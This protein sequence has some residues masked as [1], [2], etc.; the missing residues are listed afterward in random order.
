MKSV[1]FL[2]LA[3]IPADI[4]LIG[5][6][7]AFL[8][9]CLLALVL[10]EKRTAPKPPPLPGSGIP[11]ST[12]LII[13][14]ILA[15]PCILIG[16]KEYKEAVPR[17]EEEKRLAWLNVRRAVENALVACH[18][19]RDMHESDGFSLDFVAAD[20]AISRFVN[21]YPNEPLAKEYLR[22]AAPKIHE[23]VASPTQ[24]GIDEVA[25]ILNNAAGRFGFMRPSESPGAVAVALPEVIE[26][27]A[28]IRESL[29]PSQP[30]PPPAPE[31]MPAVTIPDAPKK[32]RFF[33]EFADSSKPRCS[34]AELPRTQIP[35]FLKAANFP[36]GVPLRSGAAKLDASQITQISPLGIK[37][38]T[39][40]GIDLI[41]WEA[42]APEFVDAIGWTNSLKDAYRRARVDE[43]AAA[44]YQ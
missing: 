17:W 44:K 6:L 22:A 23:L 34:M 10:A 8:L 13:A 21:D 20:Q 18:D 25:E 28:P 9:S 14:A 1:S 7:L 26:P 41:A 35:G 31:E 27:T 11:K 32:E 15:V 33:D 38:M 3:N 19:H 12:W 36:N 2:I 40:T 4:W 5:G 37:I 16:Y 24:A 30:S 29:I 42:V 39:D 43:A